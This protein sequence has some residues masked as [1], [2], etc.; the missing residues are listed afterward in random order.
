M[1]HHTLC[2]L[3]AAWPIMVHSTIGLPR[4]R[5]NLAVTGPEEVRP[6]DSALLGGPLTPVRILGAGVLHKHT[7]RTG[8][9]H[10]HTLRTGVLH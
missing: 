2:A 9:L 7:L 5:R 3:C 1:A 10:K 8:V 6:E 4:G